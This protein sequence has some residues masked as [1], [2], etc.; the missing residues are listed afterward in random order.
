MHS[1]ACSR[2]VPALGL[3]LCAAAAHADGK[4]FKDSR[5]RFKLNLPPGWELTPQPGDTEGMVFRRK[6][7]AVP[8]IVAVRVAAATAAD[9]RSSVMD[10]R[11]RSFERELGYDR[12]ND[13]DVKIGGM[14][15]LR[16]AHTVFLN[17]DSQLRR[18]SVDHVLLSFGHAHYI[19]FETAEGSYATFAKDL[20]AILASYQPVAGRKL[21][22]QVLGSWRL[23]GSGD[24]VEL[25]LGEDQTFTLG[26]RS[27]LYRVDGLRLV[28]QEA[29]GQ[30]TYRYTI[31]ED[32]LRL[33]S[34]NLAEP[35]NF[36][37]Q[38]S[39]A[40]A[41]ANDDDARAQA[42]RALKVTEQV[43]VGSWVVVEGG[44]SHEMVLSEG[45][46]VRFGPMSGRYRLKGNLLTIESASGVAVTYHVSFDGK[47]LHL[48][49]GDLDRPL[50]LERR[51]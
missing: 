41:P 40:A 16:R 45:G 32:V 44:D 19:H 47:R 30:E 11:C 49:G 26:K 25:N 31:A 29:L 39:G 21:Y 46:A 36:R 20:E 42:R 34:D 22:A 13:N 24:A 9:S 7:G 35:L 3:L 43:L 5:D 48:S 4:P 33:T 2:L 12:L 37:R 38:G 51:S 17:G 14:R 1:L 6:A 8:G 15:A 27:G 18:H 23:A 28:L 50:V 10:A